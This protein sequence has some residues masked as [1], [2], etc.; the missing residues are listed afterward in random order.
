MTR[1]WLW[2]WCSVS[3]GVDAA[4]GA[5]S[6]L[7]GFVDACQL[8]RGQDRMSGS[9]AIRA[10][11]SMSVWKQPTG[12]SCYRLRRRRRR[13]RLPICGRRATARSDPDLGRG[14]GG[15]P[16]GGSSTSTAQRIIT[17]HTTNGTLTANSTAASHSISPPGHTHVAPGPLTRPVTTG[18]G[19]LSPWRNSRTE[20][21]RMLPSL[22]MNSPVHDQP[23]VQ[24]C[25]SRVE[26]LSAHCRIATV[27]GTPT[28]TAVS[29][30]QP[31]C[32]AQTPNRA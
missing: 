2:T 5:C 14:R 17:N 20:S 19:R 15:Q 27:P 26:V 25:G 32:T 24:N 28:V 22:A 31:S 9:A 11:M 13:A 1:G 3:T 6:V 10:V 12:R 16:P 4:G 21:M 30:S 8:P 23:D 18:P 29:P 7:S